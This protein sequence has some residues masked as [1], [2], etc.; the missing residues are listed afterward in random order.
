[1]HRRLG[2]HSVSDAVLGLQD[3]GLEGPQWFLG[4]N[5][6]NPRMGSVVELAVFCSAESGVSG[7]GQERAVED[8]PMI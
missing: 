7:Q 3:D 5:Q 2:E 6:R 4:N 8:S 1:M